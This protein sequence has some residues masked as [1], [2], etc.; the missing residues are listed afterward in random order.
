[1]VCVLQ[2]A[3]MWRDNLSDRDLARAP[4]CWM[5]RY[6]ESKV[7][8]ITEPA[9][10]EWSYLTAE[11]RKDGYYTDC[12]AVDVAA[13]VSLAQF[14]EAFYTTPLFRAER[15][16]LRIAARA[17]STD[18]DVK[19]LANGASETLAAWHTE[20]RE[21]RQILLNA[22]RTKSCLMV[23][24]VETGTRLYFGSVVVPE[25]AKGGK[26]ARLGPVFD[27]LLG[28][29]KVYSRLLLA[30]AVRRLARATP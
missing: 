5:C 17:P 22:G 1:M 21:D 20:L 10:P 23:E 28:A 18:A 9:A 27:T 24:P 2:T 13:Q 19:T 3:R 14:I 8:Q 16:V 15:L 29:H 4:P 11:A 26:P 30:A 12:F 25:P 7:M 6:T